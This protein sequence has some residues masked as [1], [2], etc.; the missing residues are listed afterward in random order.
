[1]G[2]GVKIQ[3][4]KIK[5]WSH[6]SD[7]NVWS[8]LTEQGSFSSCEGGRRTRQLPRMC[9][10]PSRAMTSSETPRWPQQLP[11]GPSQHGP[12]AHT[13]PSACLSQREWFSPEHPAP[14]HSELHPH[15]CERGPRYPTHYPPRIRRGL[16]EPR[17][18]RRLT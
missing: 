5:P 17:V 2:E 13:V 7:S 1:M 6:T 10:S 11:R 4:N 12:A 3:P 16:V 9:A 15:G 8:N 14:D 18:C